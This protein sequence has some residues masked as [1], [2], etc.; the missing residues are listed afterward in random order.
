MAWP[1]CGRLAS[2]STANKVAPGQAPLRRIADLRTPAANAGVF[3]F[4]PGSNPSAPER[5]DLSRSSILFEH[6]LFGKPAPT[7]P[8]HALAT[9]LRFC[10]AARFL[11]PLALH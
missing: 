3:C 6:D 11:S 2:S 1:D 10:S 5:G 9:T 8:D 7:F 4:R